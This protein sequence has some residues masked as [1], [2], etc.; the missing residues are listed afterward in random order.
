MKVGDLVGLKNLHESW[1]SLA[2]VLGIYKT[3]YGTGQIH[4]LTLHGSRSSIPWNRR[5][6]YIV[7]CNR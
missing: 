6:E 7:E 5:D 2:L 3:D 4:L 1:G